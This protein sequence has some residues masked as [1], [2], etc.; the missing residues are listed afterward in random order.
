MTDEP[1]SPSSLDRLQQVLAATCSWP[2]EYTFKFVIPASS[3]NHLVA[4]LD[5]LPY[6]K[7]ESRGGRFL[8]ITVSARMESSEAVIALYRKT[9]NV[10]GLLSF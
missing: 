5:G 2:S 9:A 10:E 6:T 1:S 3:A 8:G 7:R 4:L